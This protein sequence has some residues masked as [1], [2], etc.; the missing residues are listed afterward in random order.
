MIVLAQFGSVASARLARSFR[1]FTSQSC[2]AA[3]LARASVFPSGE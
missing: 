2:T 3:M 1:S